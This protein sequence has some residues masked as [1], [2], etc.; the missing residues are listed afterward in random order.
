MDIAQWEERWRNDG[1]S[2][3]VFTYLAYALFV[4]IGF[5]GVYVGVRETTA[6][7]LEELSI[8]PGQEDSRTSVTMGDSSDD[9]GDELERGESESEF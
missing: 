3:P 9:G 4:A 6:Q 7:S 5:V 8:L 1:R 2:G